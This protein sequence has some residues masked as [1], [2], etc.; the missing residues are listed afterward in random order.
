MQLDEPLS[1]SVRLSEHDQTND[2]QRG[3]QNGEYAQGYEKL[4]LDPR[5]DAGE[6]ADEWIEQ[7]NDYSW[8]RNC[9][10]KAKSVPVSMICCGVLLMTL[11]SARRR[12][13]QRTVSVG[14][15]SRQL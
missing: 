6:P 13:N 4:R 7:P 5:G 8:L 9:R 10:R 2:S 12:A 1:T 15:T 11:A 3:Q 14:S